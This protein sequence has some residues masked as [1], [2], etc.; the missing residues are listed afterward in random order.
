MTD[1]T[2]DESLAPYTP[3]PG[4]TLRFSTTIEPRRFLGISLK[5]GLLNLVTLTLY[6]FWGKTEVRQRVWRG[7]RMNEEAFEYTGRGVELFVGFVIALF[8]LGLPFLAIAFGIQFIGEWFILLLL[9]LY[10]GMFWLW[11]FG[12]FTAFRYMASRTTWR[13]IR[14]RLKGSASSYGLHYLGALFLSSLTAGWFWPHAERS[15]ASKIWDELRFGD[16]RVRFRMERAERHGIYG[17]YAIGWVGTLVGYILLLIGV[18]VIGA[19][20][21]VFEPGPDGQP[22][23]PSILFTLSIYA[24]LLVVSPFALLI[25]APYQAALLRSIAAGVT[26]DKAGFKLNVKALP[27]WW[28]TVTNL[29]FLL[30]TVGFLMPWVQARTARFLIERLESAGEARLDLA[31]QTSRGPGS[32]EGLA[33]AFGFSAI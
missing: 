26:V 11:G 27:L 21:G 31:Q 15:L 2:A 30:I 16:R 32:G 28:L 25:W 10:I 8:A 14:F 22:A 18:G 9:P 17:A 24:G 6:R 3:E 19:V 13:G 5:N 12:V 1:S 29:F 7:V 20:T 33:D 23:Q 4:E